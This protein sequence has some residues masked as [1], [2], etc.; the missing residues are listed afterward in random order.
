MTRA[1][2]LHTFAYFRR[3]NKQIA[4]DLLASLLE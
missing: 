4:E 1:L 3:Q 2:A